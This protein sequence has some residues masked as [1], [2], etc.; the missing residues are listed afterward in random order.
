MNQSYKNFE[1]VIS[2]Q[3]L[4]ESIYDCFL[5]Y[6]DLININ[7]VKNDLNRGNSSSNVNNAINHSKGEYIKIL[8]QDDFLY[9]ENSLQDIINSFKNNPDKKWLITASEHTFDGIT[10]NKP[11]YPKYNSKIHLNMNTI[12]SPSVLSFKKNFTLLFD[13]NLKWLM[14]VDLYKRLHDNYG[15]PIII[16][17]INVVNRLWNKQYNNTIPEQVKTSE[18]EYVKHKIYLK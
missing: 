4:D 2:E 12:S 14:D 8:F 17:E 15:D 6:R 7:Y 18:L 3:S 16:N 9:H 13:E 10:F 11:Y 1:V 5:K